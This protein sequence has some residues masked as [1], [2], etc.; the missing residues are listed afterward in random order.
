MARVEPYLVAY[1][2]ADPKRLR[3]VHK[4]LTKWGCPVQYSVFTVDLD[5]SALERLST[6][7]QRLVS[8][9]EDDVRIYRMPK[10]AGI[11]FGAAPHGD[12]IVLTG[13]AGIDRLRNMGEKGKDEKSEEP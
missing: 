9:S 12:G 10:G 13:H 11:W 3:R 4:L 2:I 6:A 1:D 7:L 5:K 8:A